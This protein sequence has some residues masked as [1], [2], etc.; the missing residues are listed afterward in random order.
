MRAQD[1]GCLA[2][3]AL[4]MNVCQGVRV[5]ERP[6]DMVDLIEPLLFVAFYTSIEDG[7]GVRRPSVGRGVVEA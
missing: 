7:S 6:V 1:K 2:W 4:W 3:G 5:R